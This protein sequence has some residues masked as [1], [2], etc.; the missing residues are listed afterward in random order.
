ML[1]AAAVAV[2]VIIGEGIAAEAEAEVEET[3]MFHGEVIESDDTGVAREAEAVLVMVA[4][5][6]AAAPVAATA[7]EVAKGKEFVM[8]G[9]EKVQKRAKFRSLQQ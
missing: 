2:V 4:A 6:A 7:G 1:V 9:P 8:L 5:P 3:A